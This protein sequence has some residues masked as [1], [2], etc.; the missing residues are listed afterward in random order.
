MEY[1]ESHR[2]MMQLSHAKE[3]E[4]SVCLPHFHNCIEIA[5][6]L[7]GAMDVLLNDQDLTVEQGEVL[8]CSPLSLATSSTQDSRS[9]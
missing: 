5:Y 9:L 3:S 4:H 6:I 1:Y 7:D 8:L 2:D